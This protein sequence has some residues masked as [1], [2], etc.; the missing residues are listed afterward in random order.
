ME[1]NA[2][3]ILYGMLGFFIGIGVIGVLYWSYEMN[4]LRQEYKKSLDDKA[5][6][7]YQEMLDRQ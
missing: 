6:R 2:M 1:E 7:K 5:F 3:N 4:K